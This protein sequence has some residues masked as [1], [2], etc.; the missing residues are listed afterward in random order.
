MSSLKASILL[1][2]IIASTTATETATTNW[3][4]QFAQP[5]TLS[6]R[7]SGLC[8]KNLTDA[9]EIEEAL[10]F[11][12]PS[13]SIH[14]KTILRKDV[15][16]AAT[17]TARLVENKFTTYDVFDQEK[18]VTANYSFNYVEST[19]PFNTTRNLTYS[20]SCERIPKNFTCGTFKELVRFVF[21]Y[22]MAWINTRDY[23]QTKEDAEEKRVRLI[24]WS[25]TKLQKYLNKYLWPPRYLLHVRFNDME[26]YWKNL[27]GY[28]PKS[29]DSMT[30]GLGSSITIDISL[31][32]RYHLNEFDNPEFK[33]LVMLTDN[34][35]QHMIQTNSKVFKREV[36][37]CD[38]SFIDILFHEFYHSLGIGH[39]SYYMSLMFPTAVALKNERKKEASLIGLSGVQNDIYLLRYRWL[40]TNQ[41]TLNEH[42]NKGNY[43][44]EF[45]RLFVESRNYDDDEDNE[46]QDEN[47]TTTTSATSTTAATTKP[48]SESSTSSST[49][50]SFTTSSTTSTTAVTPP[51]LFPSPDP[52]PSSDDKEDFE[53]PP[54]KGPIDLSAAQLHQLTNNLAKI[55]PH[56]QTVK[57]ELLRRIRGVLYDESDGRNGDRSNERIGEKTLV[58]ML[59]NRMLRKLYETRLI[60]NDKET[61]EWL[62]NTFRFNTFTQSLNKIVEFLM[63]SF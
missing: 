17:F 43:F 55:D 14:D 30:L 53:P 35:F 62:T 48:E 38:I 5:S 59:K 12:V 28:T 58:K 44:E 52:T 51:T 61:H 40:R 3:I 33:K 4:E 2:A 31:T 9:T 27:W 8:E 36:R 45:Q 49:L 23:S 18:Y 22:T 60:G 11:N 41:Y 37:P 46:D 29:V 39:S 1:A 19:R 21:S 47:E 32:Q 50:S 57:E 7:K 24:E 6:I 20:V 13:S 56:D 15:D 42:I 54:P 10:R 16:R 34:Y 63:A 26:N 25:S